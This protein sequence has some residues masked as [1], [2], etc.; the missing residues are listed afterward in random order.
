LFVGGLGLLASP[1]TLFTEAVSSVGV[2]GP[3]SGRA[4]PAESRRT[5]GLVVCALLFAGFVITC[6]TFM[7][8]AVRDAP[9]PDKI[10]DQL[11]KKINN[12]QQPVQQPGPDGQA[13]Q[14]RQTG[15][16]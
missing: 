15:V 14:G 13:Q 11:V 12:A 9:D 6:V 3:G 5:I 8:R 4:T 2:P 10:K 1:V 16:P 7:I